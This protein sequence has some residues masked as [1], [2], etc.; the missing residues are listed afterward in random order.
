MKTLSIGKAGGRAFNVPVDFVTQTAAILARKGA[1]K[2]YTGSVFAEGL[3]LCKQQLVVIDPL[4]AWHGLRSSADG[5]GPG[6]PVVVFG[7]PHGDLP[8][9]ETMGRRL[10]DFVAEK[11]NLSCVLSLRHMR[12]NRQRQFVTDFC[13][14]LFH[15]KGNVDLAT[16]VHVMIDEADM[17]CPQ[18]V[19]GDTARLVGAMEDL[20]RRGR[21]AGIGITMITQRPASLNKDVLTQAELLIVGQITG[22]HDKKAIQEW[23]KENASDEKMGEFMKSLALLKVGEFWF[24]SPAWL[25]CLK[26]VR[27]RRRTTFDSSATPKAG[28]KRKGPSKVACVNLEELRKGLADVIEQAQ[29]NDPKALK[30]QVTSLERELAKAHK[31]KPPAAPTGYTDAEVSVLIQDAIAEAVAIRDSQWEELSIGL[32]EQFGRVISELDEL[33]KRAIAATTVPASKTRKV[34]E[35]PRARAVPPAKP[36]KPA[37]RLAKPPAAD[38]FADT[39]LDKCERKILTVLAQR[40][41]RC[42]KKLV[43][44]QAGYSVTSG[45]FGQALANLRKTQYIEGSAANLQITA[46]GIGA[47][48]DFD[49]LPEG[50]ELIAFWIR[51]RPRCESQILMALFEVMPEPMSKAEV[52][53]K[54]GYSPTSG[55][56]GQALANLRKLELIVG[57]ASALELS[58]EIFE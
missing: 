14:Q 40:G 22:P 8:L 52:S 13:E 44:L 54:C 19:M 51:S 31:A 11:P 23:I 6:Y 2:T 21:Q 42:S 27:V 53:D 37:P 32:P 36:S 38:V 50:D 24:W 16:A 35:L 48:G 4:D 39:N 10:A 58:P 47:L 18:R 26:K 17:M 57:G 34:P 1:G 41:R 29:S 45:G 43:A 49:P 15:R 25:A 9:D 46:G 3:L 55:G 5:R 28:K 33:Q 12:K 30:K 7:G 56:F 20:V